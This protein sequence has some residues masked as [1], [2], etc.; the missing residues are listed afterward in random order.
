MIY[1]GHKTTTSF[2][3]PTQE[4]LV[5][6]ARERWQAEGHFQWTASLPLQGASEESASTFDSD[7]EMSTHLENY[8][9]WDG[10][11]KVF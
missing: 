5:T 2:D 11:S 10:T 6:K 3:P 7:E 1:L 9:L 8:K 4:R